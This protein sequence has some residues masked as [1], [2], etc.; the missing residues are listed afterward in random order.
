VYENDLDSETV[1]I[2]AEMTEFNPD[3]SWRKIGADS[4]K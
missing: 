1:R 4:V 2:A 3:P